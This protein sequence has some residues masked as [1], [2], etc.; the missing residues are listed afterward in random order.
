MLLLP[1][2]SAHAFPSLPLPPSQVI[3]IGTDLVLGNIPFYWSHLPF[4][5]L[6]GLSYV[7]FAWLWFAVFEG[8]FYYSFIDYTK[9]KAW[10]AHV[11]LLAVMSAFFAF[12]AVAAPIV[13]SNYVM[14][15]AMFVGVSGIL[16]IRPPKEMPPIRAK[17]ARD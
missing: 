6:Y 11:A 10:I 8:A 15:A 3:F 2:L 14:S 1:P 13:K 4:C 16:W 9:P 7:M 5:V 12:G 17:A